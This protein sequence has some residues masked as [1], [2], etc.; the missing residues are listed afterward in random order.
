MIRTTLVLA[1]LGTLVLAGCRQDASA[2]SDRSAAPAAT[3]TPGPSQ[4]AASMLALAEAGNWT[5]YIDDFY[6][7]THKF[8]TDADRQQLIKRFENK[9]G[10]RVIELLRQVV[11]IKPQV[12]DDGSRAVFDFGPGQAFTHY[13]DQGGNWKFHLLCRTACRC[14][15]SLT[16]SRP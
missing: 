11:T 8:R 15:E 4:T 5:A 7:E 10:D 9:W 14:R 12:S 3:K 1:I 16:V 6:G 13:L 2:S